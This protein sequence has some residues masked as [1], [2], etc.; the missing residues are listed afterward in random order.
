MRVSVQIQV[1]YLRLVSMNDFY[2]PW[3]LAKHG[4]DNL[5]DG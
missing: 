4:I 2:F 5:Y 1:K 3:H